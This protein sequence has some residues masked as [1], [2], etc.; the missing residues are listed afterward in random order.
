MLFQFFHVVNTTQ[1]LMK[2]RKISL[3]DEVELKINTVLLIENELT[4]WINFL[5]E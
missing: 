2:I 5:S 3:M 1:Q 4:A